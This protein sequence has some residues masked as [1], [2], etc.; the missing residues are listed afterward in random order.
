MTARKDLGVMAAAHAV[1]EVLRFHRTE[2]RGA[3]QFSAA[4]WRTA[5][6]ERAR[7]ILHDLARTEH[8]RLP[9]WSGKDG[10]DRE[11]AALRDA[12]KTAALTFEEIRR[13]KIT[14]G[15]RAAIERMR[16][17]ATRG[18]SAILGIVHISTTAAAAGRAR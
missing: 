7:D 16:S 9:E 15:H 4:A 17:A 2:A 18:H 3:A 8:L 6:L 5:A 10:K 1:H 12:L 13:V 11:I 14:S